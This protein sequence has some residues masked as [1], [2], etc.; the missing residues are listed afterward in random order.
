MQYTWT[1]KLLI[2][3]NHHCFYSAV[4]AYITLICF[5]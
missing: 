1:T 5:A 3:Y 2:L 4:G